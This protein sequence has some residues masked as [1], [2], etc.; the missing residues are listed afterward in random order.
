MWTHSGELNSLYP[1]WAPLGE[2]N[3]KFG[4]GVFLIFWSVF[5]ISTGG[6]TSHTCHQQSEVNKELNTF[7][8]KIRPFIA[9]GWMAHNRKT[10]GTKCLEV[11]LLSPFYEQK[12]KK[13]GPN[14]N[15]VKRPPILYKASGVSGWWIRSVSYYWSVTCKISEV[16]HR[17]IFTASQ[18]QSLHTLRYQHRNPAHH[19]IDTDSQNQPLIWIF[20][21]PNS[22]LEFG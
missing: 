9:A 12:H 3:T 4:L 11:S 20:F 1:V 6:V 22:F 16:F 5:I 13:W 21:Y 2:L 7:A 18:W 8:I 10:S 19:H 17:R 14:F 15:V